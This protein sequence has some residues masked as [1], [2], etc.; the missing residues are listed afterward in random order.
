MSTIARHKGDD[1]PRIA[2]ILEEYDAFDESPEGQRMNA[3]LGSREAF[4]ALPEDLKDRAMSLSYRL[5]M[6]RR[7]V[8][9]E[10][11]AQ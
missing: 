7:T 10:R 11:R 6:A 4:A 5:N 3:A 2:V 1:D 9:Q 8:R